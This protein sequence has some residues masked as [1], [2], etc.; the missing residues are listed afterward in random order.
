MT[1]SD[2]L[3][4][5]VHIHLSVF[6]SACNLNNWF[7]PLGCPSWTQY[8]S[9]CMMWT[10]RDFKGGTLNCPQH[11]GIRMHKLAFWGFM[12]MDS[13][14][15]SGKTISK[16][17]WRSSLIGE[18]SPH[19]MCGKD[20][21]RWMAVTLANIRK[22]S[23]ACCREKPSAVQVSVSAS[24]TLVLRNMAPL[25]YPSPLCRTFYQHL[26]YVFI[27]IRCEYV[28]REGCLLSGMYLSLRWI[29]WQRLSPGFSWTQCIPK[30]SSFQIFWG[31]ENI[32]RLPD[33]SQERQMMSPL[34]SHQALPPWSCLCFPKCSA[35]CSLLIPW[36]HICKVP[37]SWKELWSH[38]GDPSR[39]E[40]KASTFHQRLNISCTWQL[41]PFRKARLPVCLHCAASGRVTLLWDLCLEC[42]AWHLALVPTSERIHHTNPSLFQ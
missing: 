1:L 26:S 32:Q 2:Y 37:Q 30:G 27:C 5:T 33:V 42:Y 31:W 41:T 17:E 36:K 6:E 3:Y 8:L 35:G 25:T 14:S 9:T 16:C 18:I 39:G 12:S 21:R 24:P 34:G 11:S 22:C 20:C 40:V 38:Q 28:I 23:L 13:H 10:E 29:D 19:R 7:F 4:F 15:I